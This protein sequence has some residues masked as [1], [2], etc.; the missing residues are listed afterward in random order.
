MFDHSAVPEATFDVKTFL[1]SLSAQPGVY[2]ML[3]AK[4]Q[5]LYIGKA[6][7]LNKRVASYFRATPATPKLRA[8]VA[9]IAAI[10]VTVTRTEGEALLLE[11]QWVKRYMPRYNICLRDDKSYP[12]VWVTDHAF[13]RVTFHRGAKTGGGQYFGPFP[14]AGAVRET[15][16][17]LPKLF[18]VRQCEDSYFASRSRPCLQHQIGRCSAPCVGLIDAQRY[19]QDVEATRLFLQGKNDTLIDSLVT[20]MEHASVALNFEQAALYRD[21]IQQLRVVLEKQFQQGSQGDCDVLA[22][23]SRAGVACVQVFFIRGGRNLGNKSYFPRLSDSA[24]PATVLSAFIAQYYLERPTPEVLVLSHLPDEAELLA[25]VLH[26]KNGRAIQLTCQVRGERQQ[27]RQMAMTNA[28]HALTLQ[29]ASRQDNQQRFISLQQALKLP[30]LPE[31]IE[32][33]DI[34]HTQGQQ[35]VASCVVFDQ[36]GPVKSAYRR[37]NIDGITPGDDYA[38]MQQVIE[39]RFKR[40]QKHAAAMPEVI[41]IDGGKGQVAAAQQA[42]TALAINGVMIVGVAKGPAR[43]SGTEQFFLPGQARPVFIPPTQSCLLL[44]QHIRDEAHRFAVKS[45]RQRRAKAGMESRLAN[46]PGLGPKRKR[47]L[48]QQFGGVPGLERA[49]IE[50]IASIQ[51]IG[52]SLAQ[53]IYHAL[54]EIDGH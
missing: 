12:Y 28:E 9:K 5:I 51:G 38:A 50:A 36:H 47:T 2:R 34:S 35:T 4:G 42:M 10:E 54:H 44:I 46:I 14:S 43:K 11:S 33:Y 29:L 16:K 41:F 18:P 7:Q 25:E 24:E 32:C 53:R 1:K 19:H 31:R 45:H 52:I 30:V 15:L 22:C 6:K 3:D 13:P 8:L 20:S 26:D 39:R 49:S 23:A 40:L 21:R 48:L 27:W 37:F 17:L